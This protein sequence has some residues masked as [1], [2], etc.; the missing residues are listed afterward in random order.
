MRIVIALAAAF[1]LLA[2][3]VVIKTALVASFQLDVAPV[4]TIDIEREQAV[5]RLARVIRFNTVSYQE[6]ERVDTAE[7]LNLHEYLKRA[8]NNGHRRVYEIK[9]YWLF[10]PVRE[11]AEI[12][13]VIELIEKDN[14]RMLAEI[15]AH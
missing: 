14:A 15:R 7:F 2:V 6:R 11:S 3:I 4:R 12:K 10:D 1:T 13:A 5:E 9:G 8:F